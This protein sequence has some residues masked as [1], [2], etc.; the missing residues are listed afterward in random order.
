[1][2]K[3]E[4]MSATVLNSKLTRKEMKMVM[5]GT[6]GGCLLACAKTSKSSDC[7]SGM[8]V[9]GNYPPCGGDHG[10]VCL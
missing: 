9:S 4:K 7:C 2:K 5:A 8:S 1:M 3:L 10:S 6:G